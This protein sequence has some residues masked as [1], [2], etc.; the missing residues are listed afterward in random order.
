MKFNIK[1]AL[2]ESNIRVNYNVYVDGYLYKV[3]HIDD[4][5]VTL[6]NYEDNSTKLMDKS[7]I[8]GCNVLFLVISDKTTK[9]ILHRD[10]V[11]VVEFLK[12][13][14]KK[15]CIL[16]GELIDKILNF[17]YK[18]EIFGKIK[19]IYT[20]PKIGDKVE[21]INLNVID[22]N[23]LH[24]KNER[25]FEIKEMIPNSNNNDIAVLSNDNLTIKCV[26]SQYK[27]MSNTN[28]KDV[29]TL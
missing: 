7:N 9:T 4:Q 29:F 11:S 28:I 5:L 21:V 13:V 26:R 19:P 6:C 16:L 18:V 25:L 14:A 23:S 8:I 27:L 2:I 12:N 24:E 15:E 17:D 1:L 10:I 22:N 20:K 3:T